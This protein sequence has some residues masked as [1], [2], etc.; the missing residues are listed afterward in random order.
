V[1][2]A[3]IVRDPVTAFASKLREAGVS[4]ELVAW[5]DMVHDFHFLAEQHRVAREATRALGEWLESR[6]RARA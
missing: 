4:T 1:G 3:E 6:S 5:P 2:E